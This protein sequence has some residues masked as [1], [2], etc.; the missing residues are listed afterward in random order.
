MDFIY[1]Y[2]DVNALKSIVD[3]QRL[4]MTDLRFLNDRTEGVGLFDF[5]GKVIESGEY[6][7]I[8]SN[9]QEYNHFF[10]WLRTVIGIQRTYSVSF[11]SDYNS[12]SQ[13]RSYC[14]DIGGYCIG[15]NSEGILDQCQVLGKG[16]KIIE[17]PFNVYARC[18]YD[19]SSKHKLAKKLMDVLSYVYKN[20][21]EIDASNIDNQPEEIK[22]FFIDALYDLHEGLSVVKDAAF[23]EEKEYR[24]LSHAFGG[25]DNDSINKPLFR[26]R[27]NLQIPYMELSFPADMIRQIVIGPCKDP[28]LARSSLIEV[29]RSA[30]DDYS[31][32]EILISEIPYRVL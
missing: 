15:F 29:L 21:C 26:S 10:H 31:H 2:T 19:D 4:W 5:I 30:D 24:I 16:D 12:L 13:W 7:D 20:A 1:H 32:V 11:S 27:S 9:E 22:Q 28:D 23:H 6:S 8:V 18:I 3:Q 14:P 25:Y 17:S